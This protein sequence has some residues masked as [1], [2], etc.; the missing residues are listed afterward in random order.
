M[1]DQYL[2][3]LDFGT[4]AG[5]CFIIDIEGR[6][7][8]SVY[9]E[10]S[11]EQP[12]DA[13]P[14]GFEFDADLFWRVLGQTAQEAIAKAG[15]NP[16]QIVAVSST[17]QRE[18]IVL[19]D[20][21]GKEI[22]AGPN[23]DLRAWREGVELSQ[24]YGHRMYELS[25]HWPNGIF[26]PARLLWL[27]RHRPQVY[28]RIFRLL[29]I[30][31]WV[32][33][34]LSGQWGCEPSNAAETCLFDITRLEWA[35]GLIRELDLPEHIFPPIYQAGECIGEVTPEAAA[36][37]GLRPGTPVVVGGADTQCG[38]LGSGGIAEGSVVAVAGTSTPVQMVLGEPLI[39]SQARTWTGP[40]VL[41]DKWVLESNAGLTGSVLRWFRDAFCDAEQVMTGAVELNAYD[42]MVEE[43]K[44]SPIG[45]N[46]VLA[47]MGPGVMNAR[48]LLQSPFSLGGFLMLSP[49]SL[50]ADKHSKRHFIRAILESLAFAIRG[51]CEQIQE[52]SGRQIEQLVVCGGSTASAFWVQMLADVM[53]IPVIVSKIREATALGC[54][55]CAGVGAGIFPDLVSGVEVLGGTGKEIKP[56]SEASKRYE[57]AYEM[58]TILRQRL[59]Q[60]S[61]AI[62]G[63]S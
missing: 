39:D 38:V 24:T 17:S 29:M 6:R 49:R 47:F 20:E 4:G 15:I 48:Q 18:G 53:R 3:A 7:V 12:P 59:A 1:A 23:R 45:S 58:W 54:A 60:W 63:K 55:I 62:K 56:R 33:Y 34:R 21:E 25:G 8:T 11:Y 50:L 16:A 51:N 19:L 14:G 22:Y 36:I 2:M 10:W 9:H 41:S 5:R 46:G 13:Q 42:L 27:R 37:T 57:A 61:T 28:K 35:Q 30:N 44:R 40:H 32:L 52:I 43:A 31:D 26:A